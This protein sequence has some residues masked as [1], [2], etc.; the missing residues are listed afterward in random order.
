MAP[1]LHRIIYVLGAIALALL[2]TWVCF[3]FAGSGHP[4]KPPTFIEHVNPP[5][6]QPSAP[7]VQAEPGPGPQAEVVPAP[8]PEPPSLR[9]S[10]P[11]EVKVAPKHH[12]R[13]VPRKLK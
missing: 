6:I 13:P 1:M 9:P 4:T 12:H 10:L 8:I 11:P 2:I 3:T 5:V 7:S